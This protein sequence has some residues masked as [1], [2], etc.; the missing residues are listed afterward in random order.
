MQTETSKTKHIPSFRWAISLFL[1]DKIYDWTFT[2]FSTKRTFETQIMHTK[3][4]VQSVWLWVLLIRFCKL[5]F[6]SNFVILNT[7]TYLVY[8]SRDFFSDNIPL[9]FINKKKERS[10]E[11][12]RQIPI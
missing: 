10:E 2:Y 8:K 1:F 11:S 12:D 3:K 6:D 5:I 9:I 7:K 4:S